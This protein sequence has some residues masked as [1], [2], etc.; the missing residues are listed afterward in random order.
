MSQKLT[1]MNIV[2][3]CSMGIL[4][5]AIAAEAF[6]SSQ[7]LIFKKIPSSCPRR[8]IHRQLNAIKGDAKSPPSDFEPTSKLYE[9]DDECEG[10]Q[11]RIVQYDHN[12]DDTKI[13]WLVED[14]IRYVPAVL[15]VMAFVLYDPVASLFATSLDA[16][17]NRN[18]V[19]VDGGAYQAKIIAPAINGI[20][21]PSVSILF[22]TLIGNT[23]TTL[24]QRQV[25]IRTAINMEAGQLWILQSM[26]EA[27]P[28]GVAKEKCQFYLIQ[29]T[30]RLIAEGHESVNLDALDWSGMDSELNGVLAELNRVSVSNQ[31]SSAILGQSYASCNRLYEERSKRVTALQ[32]TFPAL[33]YMIVSTLAISI[34]V[35]FLMETDQ[36]LLVFLNAVQLRILWTIL[37]G[38]F[39]ALAVVIFDLGNPFRG[40]YQISGSVDQ[41]YTIRLGSRA[42]LDNTYNRKWK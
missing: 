28:P 33:H 3:R 29:Y 32:S 18:W 37:V 17:A 27:F 24:R 21:V 12:E 23:I 13:S 36:V 25:D 1:M 14:F 4:P 42:S 5:L 6:I 30:S 11:C 19:A 9:I 38:T 10:D 41:L 8:M 26:L 16:I 39:S 15:P 20:V 35:V 2:M 7:I 40:S 34:C 22:A 31:I